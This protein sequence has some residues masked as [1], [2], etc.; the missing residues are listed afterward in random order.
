MNPSILPGAHSAVIRLVD[1]RL[2]N[3]DS[4]RPRGVNGDA[5]LSHERINPGI[6]LLYGPRCPGEIANSLA[7]ISRGR[8]LL[9]YNPQGGLGDKVGEMIGSVKTGG[10]MTGVAA[11][12][13]VPDGPR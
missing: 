12:R 9:G 3:V 1:G 6:E 10:R 2:C 5:R 7:E 8:Q 4:G 13:P 11:T